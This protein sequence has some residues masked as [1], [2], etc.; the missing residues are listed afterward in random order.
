MLRTPKPTRPSEVSRDEPPAK[1]AREDPEVSAL[2]AAIFEGNPL[3]DPQAR[4]GELLYS[5]FDDA[6]AAEISP[7]SRAGTC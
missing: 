3:F 6:V 2:L 1:V 7:P 4:V 5:H